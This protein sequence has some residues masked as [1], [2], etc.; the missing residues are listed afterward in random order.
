MSEWISPAAST[1]GVPSRIVHARTSSSPTVKKAIRPEARKLAATT[2]SRASSPI[3]NSSRNGAR[4]RGELEDLQLVPGGDGDGVAAAG[5]P[6]RVEDRLGGRRLAP[7]EDRH[8]GFTERKG[9]LVR[10]FFSSAVKANEES[11]FS[12]SRCVFTRPSTSRSF[13]S[14][15]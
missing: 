3:P 15:S 2:R 8:A 14:S 12:A 1:A 4:S 7:V 9:K 6:Q 11:G 5:G 13:R 10:R